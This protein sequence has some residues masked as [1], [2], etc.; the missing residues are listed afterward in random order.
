M[1]SIIYPQSPTVDS[2]K[3]TSLT[4]SYKLRAFLAIVAIILFFVLYFALVVAFAY[5]S[6]YAVIYEI[7]SYNKLTILM[8][9][10]AIAGSAML[11]IF[12]LKF[13]FKLKNNKP[14][15]R[16]LLK[17]QQHPQLWSFVDQIC[18]ETGAPKPKAIYVDPDVNAYVSYSNMWLSLFLPVKKELTI[19]LGLT[20]CLNLSEFKAVITH[21]F[22]HFAQSS[23]KIG[24]YIISANTI[25]HGMI[26]SRDKWDDILDQWRGSDI[27]VSFAAWLITPIIWIIRQLLSLFY[28]FLNI[29]YSS[30]SREMEFN[31]DKVAV[32]TTGSDAIVSAL[33]KLDD[34]ASN[35]QSTMNHAYLASQKKIF[36]NNLYE[37]N[38]LAIERGKEKQEK[39]LSEL[40]NDDRGGKLFFSGSEN[41]KVSMYASHPPNDLRENNA[42]IPYISCNEDERSPW[43]LFGQDVALQEEMTKL[44]YTQYFEKKNEEIATPEAFETFIAEE[45]KGNDLQEAY[46]NTFENRFLN[47]PENILLD[48]QSTLTHK[49][50]AT[51]VATL[52]TTLKELMQPVK[53]IETL[54]LKAQEISNGT[55]KEKSFAFKGITYKRN[56]LNEGYEKLNFERE[57]LFN[58]TF[59]EWDHDFIT[60]HIKIANTT[61]DATLLKNKYKQHREIGNIYQSIVHV[62]KTIFSELAHIQS[63]SEV[64]KVEVSSFGK[65]VKELVFSINKDIDKLDNTVFVPL[66]NIDSLEE[67]KEAIIEGG[68]FKKPV[69]NLFEGDGFSNVVTTIENALV[70]CQRVEQKSINAILL[71]QDKMMEHTILN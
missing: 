62:K 43:L 8:K 66:P 37:H 52:K 63:K 54:M 7:G 70:H 41:S 25:I 18:K 61:G 46:F 27:R 64:S 13:I 59:K 55:T 24:S 15:N 42:K 2:K 4:S 38:N 67:L 49:N 71:L 48:K 31:A 6:Y 57:Q 69:G 20:S 26:F 19:G 65:K 17:K 23:M 39:K 14:V 5:L 32:S 3:L 29:M 33:W 9:I 53:E 1:Q 16:I 21:E 58:N 22:G 36:V 56:N 34:G 28:Q 40:P 44:V 30:L 51:T 68:A 47:I 50:I 11:F 10:G 60:T 35:W 12:T 45:T